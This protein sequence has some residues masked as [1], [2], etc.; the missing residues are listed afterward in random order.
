MRI[1]IL[2]DSICPWCFIGKRRFERALSMRPQQSLEVVWKPFQ[3]NPTMPKEGIDR[4]QYLAAKFGGVER[5]DRQYDR[6]RQVGREEGIA[7]DFGRIDRT[8]NTVNSH[9]LVYL[10]G[11][12]GNQDAVV[13]GLFR[14]YFIEGR[15]VGDIAVLAD[16]AAAVG[17]DRDEVMR[18]LLGD[19]DQFQ[20]LALDE[21]ARRNGITGVPCFIVEDRYAISGAQSPEIFHQIFDLVRQEARYPTGR[22]AAE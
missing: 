7:F 18:Y 2:S 6:I 19:E 13:E 3:L 14:A 10:A 12:R 17:F 16:V 8:P 22:S 5:A 1:T 15:D 9:R 20:I 11:Q 4:K 21:S